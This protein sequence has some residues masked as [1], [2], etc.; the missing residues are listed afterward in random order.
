[1]IFVSFFDCLEGLCLI[2]FFL[3]SFKV[4]VGSHIF[5]TQG[6]VVNQIATIE[7]INKQKVRDERVNATCFFIMSPFHEV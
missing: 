3:L 7:H 4:L 2:R 5:P 6:R 1:M